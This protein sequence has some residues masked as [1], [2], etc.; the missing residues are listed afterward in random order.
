MPWEK[1]YLLKLMVFRCLSITA[2]A[3]TD[4][5]KGKI[6]SQDNS[7]I[8]GVEVGGVVVGVGVSG[9]EEISGGSVFKT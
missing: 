5:S 4:R 8:L 1:V 9:D 2:T 3:N 7:G 6:T